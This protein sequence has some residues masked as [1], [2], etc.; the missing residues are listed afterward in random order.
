MVQ[1]TLRSLSLHNFGA[2]YNLQG[3][4]SQAETFYRKA[5]GMREKALGL[6]HPDVAATLT[7]LAVSY[8]YQGRYTEATPLVKRAL[9]INEKTFGPDHPTVLK[10]SQDYSNLLRKVGRTKEA[11]EARAKAIRPGAK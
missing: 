7:G 1:N 6:K 9:E 2:L 11:A 5:L 8:S 4:Y 3:N 10:L